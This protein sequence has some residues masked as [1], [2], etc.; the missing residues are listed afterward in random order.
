MDDIGP[1][2]SADS[3]NED[4]SAVETLEDEFRCSL[5]S[6]NEEA[7]LDQDVTASM[8]E[9]ITVPKLREPVILTC[10]TCIKCAKA[11]A[12]GNI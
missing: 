8:F 6:Q 2:G 7:I 3:D 11:Y 9:E 4:A 10:R 12:Y 1:N 5:P